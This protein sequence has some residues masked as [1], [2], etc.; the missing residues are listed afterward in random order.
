LLATPEYGL[1]GAKSK[2]GG[3]IIYDYRQNKQQVLQTY[4]GLP[5]NDLTAVA[6]D[7]RIAWVGGRGFVAVI[8]VQQRKVLRIAYV[9]AS[10]IYGI[11]LSPAHAWVALSCVKEEDP[12]HCGNARTGVYRMNRAEIESVVDTASRK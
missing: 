5:S 3:L 2:T 6:V 8:D 11:Q 12:D 10:R 4:Q 7:G 9:S 1:D